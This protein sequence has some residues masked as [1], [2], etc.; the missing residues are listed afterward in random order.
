MPRIL[1]TFLP[2]N[3]LWSREFGNDRF[4][5]GKIFIDWL[6]QT[7]QNVWQMLPLSANTWHGNEPYLLSPYFGYGVGLNPFYLYGGEKKLDFPKASKE[8]VEENEYW[9][10]D[11]ANF[12]A[13]AEKF[14]SDFWPKWPAE[15]QNCQG[16]AVKDFSQKN[17]TRI[18]YI[19]DQQT[20]LQAKFSDLKA[21]ASDKKVELW[22]DMPFYLPLNS[23]LVWANQEAFHVVWT[24]DVKYV[25]GVPAEK[26]FPRQLWGHPLYYWDDATRTE[27]ILNT[28]SVRLKFLSELYTTVR[29]DHAIGFYHYGK[30]DP[31]GSAKDIVA[32]GPGDRILDRVIKLCSQNGLKF[33]IEDI[34]AFDLKELHKTMQRFDLPGMSVLTMSLTKNSTKV[35]K[36]F[37]DVAKYDQNHIFYTSTHDVLPLV[38][39]LNQLTI[40]Q[41]KSLAAELDVRFEEKVQTLALLVRNKLVVK[42]KILIVP[43]QDWLLR[44]E[45]INVPGTVGKNNWN[46]RISVPV[47]DLPSSL[48]NSSTSFL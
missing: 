18:N 24:G 47:E 41:K 21:Y 33:I 27:A 3:S 16:Q 23:P 36:S 2:L 48:M 40:S 25:S 17:S 7:G 9:L 28:W 1:G 38:P 45:R 31:N 30:L 44:T 15:L 6:C 35:E 46:Y 34:S 14:G 12:L 22:G 43:I 10:S 29:L 42:S 5:A 26:Y 39:F 13:L 32:T 37:F 19:I 4:A 8:F 11:Y 20:Y